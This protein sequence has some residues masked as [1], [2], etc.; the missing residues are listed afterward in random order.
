MYGDGMKNITKFS[1]NENWAYVLIYSLQAYCNVYDYFCLA[2]H[3]FHHVNMIHLYQ[4][5][6]PSAHDF[7][8]LSRQVF[9]SAVVSMAAA[10][11]TRNLK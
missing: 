9:L 6:I 7:A 5:Y 2:M 3:I 8:L 1:Y 10:Y 4:V 11:L